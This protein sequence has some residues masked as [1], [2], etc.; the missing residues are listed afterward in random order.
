MTS[1]SDGAALC[2]PI[3]CIPYAHSTAL[4]GMFAAGA[5]TAWHNSLELVKHA[6]RRRLAEQ[7]ATIHS[8]QIA[9]PDATSPPVSFQQP[10]ALHTSTSSGA[11]RR[12]MGSERAEV[13]SAADVELKRAVAAGR[14]AFA[15]LNRYAHTAVAVGAVALVFGGL[16]HGAP[17]ASLV[18]VRWRDLATSR[19]STS[20]QPPE[21]RYAHAAC[22]DPSGGMVVCGGR[23]AGV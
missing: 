1:I 20:G 6:T 2:T 7:R 14:A 8:H 16:H 5:L 11:L 13:A 17:T 19:L 12:G 18:S 3:T 22:A 15:S 21:P 4:H 10:H 23:D 9:R